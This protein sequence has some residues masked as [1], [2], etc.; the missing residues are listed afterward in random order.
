MVKHIILWQLKDEYSEEQKSEIR[1]GIK[2]GLEGLKGQIP[3]LLSIHVQ[4]EYL[5]SSNVDVMLDSAFES[6]EALK[7]YSVHPA[8]VAVANS[9]V[10]PFTK[11]RTC[12]DY[13]EEEPVMMSDQM[14]NE[15]ME[16]VELD[17]VTLI[18]D[19]AEKDYAVCCVFEVEGED[20]A[21]LCPIV[22]GDIVDD[23]EVMFFH[24]K[25]E[26]DEVILGEIETEEEAQAIAE[27][28]EELCREEE[29]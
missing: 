2:E 15:E 6:E 29:L 13:E 19:G 8:H 23:T 4:T 18:E 26:G 25:E 16:E 1:K 5:S 27:E 12:I 24:Y 14:K 10:R 17:V 28:Y 9:K 7:N 20:Y 22:E 21:A 3:G 11:L